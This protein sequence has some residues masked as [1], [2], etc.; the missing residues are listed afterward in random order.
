MLLKTYSIINISSGYQIQQRKSSAPSGA[1]QVSQP[2]NSTAPAGPSANAKGMDQRHRLGELTRLI[3][4]AEN[5][6]P[7][8]KHSSRMRTARVPPT[9]QRQTT[10]RQTSPRGRP[11]T[12]RI[13]DGFENITLPQTLFVGGKNHSETAFALNKYDLEHCFM[14]EVALQ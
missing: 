10:C 8:R 3:K 5:V 4:S 1:I 11:P 12:D 13:T 2:Q 9:C 6:T 14:K 7:A